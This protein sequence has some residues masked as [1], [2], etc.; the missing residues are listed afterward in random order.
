MVSVLACGNKWIQV[1]T[2][3]FSTM[4]TSRPFYIQTWYDHKHS[5]VQGSIFV[6]C[7]NFAGT[8]SR[9]WQRLLWHDIWRSSH[10]AAQLKLCG[11]L[12]RATL[13]PTVTQS[14]DRPIEDFTHELAKLSSLFSAF[15]KCLRGYCTTG[16]YFWRLCAFSQKIKQLRTK[17]P[18]DLGRNV[19]K[20]SKITVLLQ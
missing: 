10:L 15:W 8:G 18:T 6:T 3:T 12:Y 9:L 7:S 16:H 17:Y 13:D 1:G 4:F 14:H 5:N 11:Q 20:N 2:Y 19:P